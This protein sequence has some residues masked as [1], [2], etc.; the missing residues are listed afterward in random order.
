VVGKP[1]SKQCPA[2]HTILIRAILSI[3]KTST[4]WKYGSYYLHLFTCLAHNILELNVIAGPND[5]EAKFKVVRI[6]DQG[7]LSKNQ[8]MSAWTNA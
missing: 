3:G 1:I 7:F 6:I 4:A 2:S 5:F 8:V